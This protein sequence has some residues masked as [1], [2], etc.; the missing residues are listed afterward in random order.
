MMICQANATIFIGE[1]FCVLELNKNNLKNDETEFPRYNILLYVILAQ[2]FEMRNKAKNT[3]D[4][5]MTVN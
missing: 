2:R 5:Q 3:R 1:W 4:I